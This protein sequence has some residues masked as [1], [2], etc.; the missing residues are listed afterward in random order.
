[1]SLGDKAEVEDQSGK[2]PEKI[3]LKSGNDSSVSNFE[4]PNTRLMNGIQVPKKLVSPLEQIKRSK[5]TKCIDNR[6]RSRSFSTRGAKL[7]VATVANA[8]IANSEM[9]KLPE[10]EYS[11]KSNN[12]AITVNT[13]N[14]EF[15]PNRWGDVSILGKRKHVEEPRPEDLEINRLD[16]GIQVTVS[17]D[18]ELDYK[19]DVELLQQNSSSEDDVLFGGYCSRPES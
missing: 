16:D 9:I 18:D 1:M 3:K 10:S 19:D 12:N 6:S 4:R 5:T 11:D 15:N 7:T 2:K 14:P 13:I 8:N 17:T